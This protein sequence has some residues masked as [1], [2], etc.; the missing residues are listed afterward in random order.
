MTWNREAASAR[1]ILSN[2][3]ILVGQS[4]DSSDACPICSFRHSALFHYPPTSNLCLGVYTQQQ[5]LPALRILFQMHLQLLEGW[6][7]YHI[8]SSNNCICFT[9]SL[10]DNSGSGQILALLGK[11]SSQ[12]KKL[13]DGRTEKGKEETNLVDEELPTKLQD[14]HTQAVLHLIILHLKKKISV[15]S[16][17]TLLHSIKNRGLQLKIVVSC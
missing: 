3:L 17:S 14:S 2:W 5:M 10:L 13:R 1:K 4:R 15:W 6:E 16:H 8:I 9:T 12:G 11:N 7:N